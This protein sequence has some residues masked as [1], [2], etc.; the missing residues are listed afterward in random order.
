[1]TIRQDIARSL[2]SIIIIIFYYNSVIIISRPFNWKIGCYN[3]Q[4]DN[5]VPVI[6][7]YLRKN[8][9]RLY[10]III[11]IGLCIVFIFI[12]SIYTNHNRALAANV[13]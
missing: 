9:V 13:S 2:N 4:R 8:T 7:F 1:M 3:D 5:D 6:M 10:A 11:H 12:F